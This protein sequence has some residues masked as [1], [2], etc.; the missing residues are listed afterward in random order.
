MPAFVEDEDEDDD[1]EEEEDDEDEDGGKVGG[2]SVVGDS[3]EARLSTLAEL[4]SKIRKRKQLV[5]S[6]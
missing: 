5:H 6:F 3:N 1:D 2:T 4:S